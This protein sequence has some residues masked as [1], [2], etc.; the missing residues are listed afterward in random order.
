MI[1]VAKK[2]AKKWAVAKK[3]WAFA[4][5]RVVKSRKNAFCGQK[6]GHLPTF[7]NGFG[8]E[9]MA[10]FQRLWAFLAKNPLFY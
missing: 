8:H 5:I 4:K 2:W 9:E 7:K 1:F 3:F 6:N 10:Y